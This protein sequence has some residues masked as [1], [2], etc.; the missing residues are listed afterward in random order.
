MVLTYSGSPKVAVII[1]CYN[2]K[3]Y[4][5]ETV[6]S[7]LSQTYSDIEL[8]CVDDGCTDGTREILNSYGDRITVLE[9]QGRVNK[10][11]SAAINLG[12]QSSESDYVS[13]LD[14]DDLFAPEKLEYQVKYLEEHPEIGYM[15]SNGYTI[16]GNGNKLFKI[17]PDGYIAPNDPETVLLECPLGTPSGYLV[18]RMVFDQAG[19]FDESFRSSQDHDMAIRLAEVS[20]I[21]YLNDVHW[22]KREHSDS[23]SNLQ[24][25]RRW[26]TGLLILKKACRRYPYSFSVRR[27]RL[28]ILH[29]RLG[30]CMLTKSNFL[31]AVIRFTCAGLLDPKRAFGVVTGKEKVTGAY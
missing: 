14:S 29:F 15:Y 20:Q 24:A 1:P 19:Y 9:H 13:V 22:Y 23:L 26:R 4:I 10:G 8:I 30:Q 31:M 28:A 6:N 5:Q 17:F 3:K 12:I 11:Q 7:V 21:G 16:D 25:E 2:R 27:R 18:R